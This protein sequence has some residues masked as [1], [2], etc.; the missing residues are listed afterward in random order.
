L[1]QEREAQLTTNRI[2]ELAGVSVGSLYQYF[3]NKEA[4]LAALVRDMRR[5]ML[6]DI[7]EAE[8]NAK[9]ATLADTVAI[10]V[11]AAIAHHARDPLR[12]QK[13]EEVERA[14]DLDVE[15]QDLKREI[16]AI[17]MRQLSLHQIEN[18]QIAALDLTA[19][20]SGMAQAA[21][22]NGERDFANLAARITR[23]ATGYLGLGSR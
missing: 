10:L 17:I 11:R 19:I 23:A 7:K 12:S 16:H 13:I 6:E 21:V 8:I 4:I 9:D 2:A 3:P 20:T 5:D 14:F 1:E 18:A 22:S 15:T